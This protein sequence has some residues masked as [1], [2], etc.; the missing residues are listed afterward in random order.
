MNPLRKL[1]KGWEYMEEKGK[2][3][4]TDGLPIPPVHYPVEIAPYYC[5]ADSEEFKVGDR[6]A[7]E[8]EDVC[9][10]HGCHGVV[11]EKQ[12]GTRYRVALDGQ[13]N[14]YTYLRRHLRREREDERTAEKTPEPPKNPFR[15]L[16]LEQREMI[17]QSVAAWAE[18]LPCER[19]GEAQP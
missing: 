15:P 1:A 5:F 4:V 6:V 8:G 2:L 16:T 7:I 19:C 17:R 12:I 10:F 14:T 11:C 13:P 18:S 3:F 9:V